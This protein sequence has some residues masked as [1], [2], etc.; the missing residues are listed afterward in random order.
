MKVLHVNRSDVQ[1][2]AARAVYRI[3]EALN[4]YKIESNMLVCNSTSGDRSVKC[5]NGKFER[6]SLFMRQRVARVLVKCLKTENR[7]VHS[8]A[9]LPS[10][11][12]T[13]I[14]ETDADLLNL[15]W[16]GG[17]MLSI[18]DIGRLRKPVVWTLHDMWGF[19]GAEHVTFDE[20]WRH[21]YSR[22]NRPS[23]ERG[24][25]LNR[26]TWLR[27]RYSWRKPVNIITPSGWL[28]DCV[29]ESALMREWPV[30]VIP[31]CLDTQRW[32]P[33]EKDFARDLLGLPRDVPLIMFVVYEGRSGYNKGTD[34][35]LGALDH[36]RS[37]KSDIELVALGDTKNERFDNLGFTM[38]GI[39]RLHDDLS[40]SC[41]YSACDALVVPSRCEAFCQ[42]A[43]EAQACGTP[44]A[45]FDVGG[46][47]DII[48][49]KKTGYLAKAFD[50]VDLAEAVN[51]VSR[52][53]LR[54]SSRER[55]VEKFSY[56]VVAAQ[57][58]NEYRRILK[59]HGDASVID[60]Y[61]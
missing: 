55:A 48:N 25:D 38:H 33:I 12:V 37:D 54:K 61:T 27:K 10:G 35:L 42:I 58:A 24:L 15:H 16:V 43:V 18:G 11:N 60:Q 4:N 3:H 19:C 46:L 6:F 14:N 21:G 45:A 20:R 40:L 23:Y 5:L 17:E 8:P 56:E 22:T 50:T 52:N 7:T 34:L 39:G 47:R 30:N 26:L 36:L 1:G 41:A 57:Y 31:N 2:G 32:R 59:H 53:D 51:W 29:L 9:V 49:H 44:V 13:K 28:R